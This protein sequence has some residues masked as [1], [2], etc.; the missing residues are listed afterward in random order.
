M[1]L[2]SDPSPEAPAGRGSPTVTSSGSAKDFGT[3]A[4]SLGHPQVLVGVE[5]GS[6]GRDGF[7][8]PEGSTHGPTLQ[9]PLSASNFR[10]GSGAGAGAR[11]TIGRSATSQQADL[12]NVRVGWRPCKNSAPASSAPGRRGVGCQAFIAAISGP[13]PR[14]CITR[15]MLVASTWRPIFPFLFCSVS[16]LDA[17][18][19]RHARGSLPHRQH[20]AEIRDRAAG[21]RGRDDE[22]GLRP[23]GHALREDGLALAAVRPGVCGRAGGGAGATPVVAPLAVRRRARRGV[24]GAAARRGEAGLHSRRP[25]DA[26]P[27]SL[28]RLA[29]PGAVRRGRV[30]DQAG[31]AARHRPAKRRGVARS[32]V[33]SPT[34][35][36]CVSGAAGPCGRC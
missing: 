17:V 6:L 10:N 23:T 3:P 19:F 22:P 4:H 12:S 33:R 11:P 16:T 1:R 31:A 32:T 8:R 13:V 14:I 20:D 34:A 29:Q 18:D 2:C 7:S 27:E 9:G 36:S 21:R 26:E 25:G 15:F 24:P 35:S 30:A 5:L 28:H